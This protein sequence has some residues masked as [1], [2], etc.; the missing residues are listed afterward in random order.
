MDKRRLPFGGLEYA[1]LAV[2]LL[3]LFAG[4][5]APWIMPYAPDQINMG[6][7]LKAPGAAYLLGTDPLGRD[8][9]SRLIMG[10]RISIGFAVIT[11]FCTMGVGLAVGILSGWC[12]GKVDAAIQTVVNIF[13][14]VPSFSLM[15]ALAGILE[16]GFFSM[17]I[18]IVATSWTGFSRVVRGEVLRLKNSSFVEGLR[19]LGAEPTFIIRHYVLRSL[20]PV[21]SVLFTIRVGSVLLSAAGLS[22]IGIGLQPPLADWGLMV[23]EGQTY[24]RT[25][26]LLLYA[27]GTCIFFLCLS[28][29]LLGE[30]LKRRFMKPDWLGK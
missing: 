22:Y 21:I 7:V 10:A 25:Y 17:L 16:P 20:A 5:L 12:G 18:A 13:Q 8:I 24:C 9:L 19:A 6:E 15:I 1:A 29:N 30:S 2:L 14:G 27:P 11:A 3:F 28:V 26:P 23:N 4:L